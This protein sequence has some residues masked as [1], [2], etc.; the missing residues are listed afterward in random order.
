MAVGVGDVA[1]FERVARRGGGVSQERAG[2]RRGRQA[3]MVAGSL[4]RVDVVTLTASASSSAWRCP[5]GRGP[6]HFSESVI[7]L[8]TNP[9]LRLYF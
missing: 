4:I 3:Q 8:L 2:G 5:R 9:S 7:R 6:E 1:V